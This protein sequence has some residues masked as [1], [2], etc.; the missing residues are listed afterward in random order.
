MRVLAVTHGP[1][2]GPALFGDVI[3]EQGHELVEWP[4]DV[5]GTPASGDHD[6]VFVFGGHQNV[7]EEVQYPWLHEEYEALR[8]WVDDGT[9][10]FAVC[11]GAQTLSHALGGSVTPIEPTQ[12]AGFYE[13]ELTAEGAADPVLG[14]LPRRFGALNANAY[15]FT[16]PTGGVSLADAQFTQA[17]R[18]GE[19]AWGVQFHPEVRREQVLAW[20]AEDEPLLSR[21]L[22]DLERELDEN[23]SDWQDLGRRLCSA[24]LAVAGHR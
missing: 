21:P 20:Y 9:P 23:I 22:A 15:A 18:A 7:G 10:L 8:R 12:L 14:V 3:A 6:A 13:T 2:V 5:R 16:V 17:F 19:S 4:I 24:F 1:N 11:L